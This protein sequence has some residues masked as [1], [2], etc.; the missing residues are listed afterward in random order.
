MPAMRCPALRAVLF[1][2]VTIALWTVSRPALAITMPAPFCDDRGATGIAAD[3]LLEAPDVAV[4]R[5]RVSATC[6]S[7]EGVA[8]GA[9]VGLAHAH[10]PAVSSAP[11]PALPSATPAVAPPAFT[12]LAFVEA[13]VPR[14][15]G[16]PHALDRPPRT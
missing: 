10:A 7:S 5:A 1:A 11:Q 12:A 14:A 13:A 16:V 4:Q 6:G 2:V 3:P 9:A 15:D 8:F